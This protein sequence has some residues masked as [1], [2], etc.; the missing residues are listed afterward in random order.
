MLK[1][2]LGR[3]GGPSDH[4]VSSRHTASRGASARIPSADRAD[5]GG[6][7]SPPAVSYRDIRSRWK[8]PALH[9]IDA[10]VLHP[11]GSN[12]SFGGTYGNRVQEL[13]RQFMA[14]WLPR[15]DRR[16]GTSIRSCF[17]R[18]GSLSGVSRAGRRVWPAVPFTARGSTAGRNTTRALGRIDALRATP[19]GVRNMT[20]ILPSIHR[21][22]RENAIVGERRPTADRRWAEEQTLSTI[23]TRRP[24]LFLRSGAPSH[25]ARAMVMEGLAT[26]A[27]R[28]Y[29]R[30][31]P[32]ASAFARVRGVETP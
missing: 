30:A 24:P 10:A 3:A 9:I 15:A 6:T 18:G 5:R 7:N 17:S 32:R 28:R 26:I 12:P 2:L 14:T 11:D 25:G 21:P 16:M 1:P 31:D 8:T 29:R 13:H 23:G 19:K 4:I 22:A 27:K 20:N